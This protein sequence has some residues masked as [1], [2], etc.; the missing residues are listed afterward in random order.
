MKNGITHVVLDFG[1]VIA[2]I[3]MSGC[4]QRYHALGFDNVD[5]Y[6]NLVCQEGF[7]GDF[8]SGRIDGKQLA[9]F[10]SREAGKSLSEEECCQAFLGF[11]SGMDQTVLDRNLAAVRRLRSEGYAL[12]LLSNTNP[13]VAS[14]FRSD[15]FDGHGHPLTDYLGHFYL[16]FEM[17]VM[18]PDEKIFR[19]MLE[20]ESVRPEQVLYV[21]DGA[22]NIATARR[23]GLHTLLASPDI[24]WTEEIWKPLNRPE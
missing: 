20:S 9:G 10:I 13:F 5:K 7:F 11:F 22:S 14:W 23:L 1:G 12:A 15:R 18:K 16:S 21:D 19:M 3:N 2:P 8:E 24:D 17:K 4:L 6:L